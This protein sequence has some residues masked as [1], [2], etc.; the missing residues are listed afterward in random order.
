MT[1][2]Y[3]TCPHQ[4][5]PVC[6]DTFGRCSI[7]EYGYSVLCYGMPQAQEGDLQGAWKCFR[8]SGEHSQWRD[9]RVVLRALSQRTQV[10]FVDINGQ[11]LNFAEWLKIPSEKQGGES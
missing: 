6:A 7:N 8:Q 11:P 9:Q 1:E 4:P 2:Y 10:S 3:P 5:C